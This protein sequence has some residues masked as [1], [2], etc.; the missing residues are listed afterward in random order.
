MSTAALAMTVVRIIAAIAYYLRLVSYEPWMKA[1]WSHA[2]LE[3]IRRLAHPAFASLSMTMST[4]LSLQ[5]LILS[6]GFFVS[7]A[8]TAIFATARTIT[9]IPLQVV[10]LSS[11][12]TL[13][14]MTAA[15]SRGDRALSAN[16]V[17]LN[18]G[19]TAAVAAPFTIIFIIL[20]PYA[21]EL[22]SRHRMHAGSDLFVWL[23]LV[24]MFQAI[25]ST[26]GQ[27]LFAINKQH[28]F[29]YHYL[30]LA[31]VTAAAPAFVG[32]GDTVV[33]SAMVWCVIEALMMVIVYRAWWA[34]T[35]LDYSVFAQSASRIVSDAKG[36]AQQ[37]LGRQ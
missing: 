36:L 24:A 30:V 14:E 13:P 26:F 22:L 18:L 8:A 31:A 11:R 23:A 25:W 9:R 19:F 12:A 37:M 15:F 10:G 17:V 3:T 34:E 27:F 2:S 6:L 1:G 5:G 35:D 7:P 4:A 29:A 21:L 28:R 20:G 33:R 16:L 32:H